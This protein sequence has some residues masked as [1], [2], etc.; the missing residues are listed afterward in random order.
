MNFLLDNWI[1]V[2]AALTS[3]GLLLWPTL[4]SGAQGAAVNA[5]EAVRLMNR[6]KAVLIDVCEPAEFAAGHVAG[7]RNVPLA[8]LEGHK[9]LPSNKSLPVI[10][11]C[12]SGARAARAAA[13]LRK[14]G[15]EKAQPLAGGL[16]AWREASL[17]IEKSA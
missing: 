16:N 6:E 4:A 3:G 9:S 1:L 11:V 14:L 17:P 8:S 5:A 10:V 12:Q 7:A 2:L 13:Q 15:Y